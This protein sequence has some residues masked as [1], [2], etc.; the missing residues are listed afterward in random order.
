[1]SYEK[2]KKSTGSDTVQ[3]AVLAVVTV[4]CVYLF[5][6]LSMTFCDFIS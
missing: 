3:S 5:S 6:C 2:K 1:M 4:T